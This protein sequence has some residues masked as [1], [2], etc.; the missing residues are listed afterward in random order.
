[1]QKNGLATYKDLDDYYR[2]RLRRTLAA[3]LP[4]KQFM[5]WGVGQNQSFAEGDLVDWWG[6]EEEFGRDYAGRRNPVVVGFY[7]RTYLD[8]GFWGY[9]FVRTWRTVY[10]INLKW[11]DVNVVGLQ[12]CL[13]SEVNNQHT[14]LPKLLTRSAAAAE[15]GWNSNVYQGEKGTNFTA[16][17]ARLATHMDRLAARGL[18]SSPLS[19]ELCERQP[20]LC[21]Q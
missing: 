5:F 18:K 7:N 16:L 11:A 19:N 10:S 15:R 1:M 21:F 8:V 2:D 6:N 12:V 20:E 4:T 13:W 3:A 14:Q 17:T 9:P